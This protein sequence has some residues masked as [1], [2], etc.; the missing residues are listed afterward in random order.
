[1][2]YNDLP[3]STLKKALS[4][5]NE[6]LVSKL[7]KVFQ[8]PMEGVKDLDSSKRQQYDAVPLATEIFCEVAK[9]FF[10]SKIVPLSN[11]PMRPI[12][13]GTPVQYEEYIDEKTGKKAVRKLTTNEYDVL[14][15]S[16]QH[17]GLDRTLESTG[18]K[19]GVEAYTSSVANFNTFYNVLYGR[20][21]QLFFSFTTVA[22]A[23]MT[24]KLKRSDVVLDNGDFLICEPLLDGE[25]VAATQF[26]K[27][28]PV[29]K[30]NLDN[31]YLVS[32]LGDKAF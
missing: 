22:I 23:I 30:Y 3:Q 20:N 1:M 5:S 28:K 4:V 8:D 31:T 14:L 21:N 25:L 15:T 27:A 29:R 32:D 9:N 10:E 16:K 6:Q 26:G 7:I 2:N 24:G 13:Y 12:R 11:P 18:C 19:L 17:S